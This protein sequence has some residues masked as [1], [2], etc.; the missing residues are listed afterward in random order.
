MSLSA[1]FGT[2][3]QDL[4]KRGG[5]LINWLSVVPAECIAFPFDYQ[6]SKDKLF[7]EGCNNSMG[8]TQFVVHKIQ[9]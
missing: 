1:M 9:V 4:I 7:T 3:I 8:N 5:S 6:I 2:D